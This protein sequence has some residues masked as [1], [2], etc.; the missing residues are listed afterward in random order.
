MSRN[1]NTN[2]RGSAWSEAEKKA[3]WNNADKIPNQN[4]NLVRRDPCGIPIRW[5]HH[6]NTKE[7]TGWEIDHIKPVS[8]Q[9]DDNIGNLQ[10]LQWEN[11]RHK[12]DNWPYWECKYGS[13]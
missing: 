13:K 6:G 12:A 8:E 4:E 3:V 7:N 9:G 1:R 2:K 5:E 11:N 10:A